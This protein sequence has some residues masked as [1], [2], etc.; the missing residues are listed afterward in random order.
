MK[1]PV[2]AFSSLGIL[3]NLFVFLFAITNF[4]RFM[5]LKKGTKL[6]IILF[7]FFAFLNTLANLTMLIT[8]ILDPETAILDF[9]IDANDEIHISVI[10]STTTYIGL[11]LSLGLSM[12]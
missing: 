10:I 2:I 9:G 6:L 11:F 5:Y 3:I 4:F 7:Y 12:Y 1:V 8:F